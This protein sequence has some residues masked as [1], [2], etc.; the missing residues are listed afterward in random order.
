ME[1]KK[2]VLRRDF[3]I[4]DVI[5]VHY[6]EYTVDFAFSGELHDFWEFVYVDKGEIIITADDKDYR[7]T[8][9]QVF[10]HKPNQWHALRSNGEIAPNLVVVSFS[11]TS[12]AM[13]FFD[14]KLLSVGQTQKSLISKII[15]EFTSAFSTP[16][17]D[18][19]TTYLTR[20]QD[21]MPGS[22]Q[23]IKIYLSELLILFMRD[24]D[25]G[26]YSMSKSNRLSSNMEY[27][28][29]HMNSNISRM[30]SLA[31][32]STY[33]GMSKSAISALFA[34]SVGMGPI[35]YFIKMKINLAKK[36]IREDNYNITQISDILGYSSVH[37]FSRQ[38][39]KV[40]GMSP[41]QYSN[42]IKALDKKF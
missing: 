21:I 39:K 17:S 36:Y 33:S 25:I 40:T 42:S 3:E 1:Y 8:S 14:D 13:S 30:I 29:S 24:N 5:S 2:T 7:L 4:T 23:L 12:S 22:E 6:F 28:L 11:C 37:Y 9:G 41:S 19:T 18:H 32:L 10:F 15:T 20:R 16:V 35:E 38:F 27:I 26:Q 31:E 34:A